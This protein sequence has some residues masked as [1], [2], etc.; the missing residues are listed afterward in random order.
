[1]RCRSKTKDRQTQKFPGYAIVTSIQC[2]LKLRFLAT[3]HPTCGGREFPLVKV[4]G[5]TRRRPMS[6]GGYV[7]RR[8][9]EIRW[10]FPC[11]HGPKCLVQVRRGR[12]DNRVLRA[13]NPMICRINPTLY[14]RATKCPR[15]AT[16]CPLSPCRAPHHRLPRNE[17]I[18]PYG[19][20]AVVVF[21]L[22]CSEPTRSVRLIVNRNT[23]PHPRLS[24]AHSRPP[25]RFTTS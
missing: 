22:S 24:S 10:R 3:Y 23:V 15:S 8:H 6:A 16:F 21:T 19:I 14:R 9:S 7:P 5:L 12:A 1:M 2:F 25:C 20:M 11:G 13:I 17:Q 18:I 4:R